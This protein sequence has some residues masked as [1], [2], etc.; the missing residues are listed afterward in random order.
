MY[1]DSSTSNSIT[2]KYIVVDYDNALVKEED[3]YLI[4]YT[5]GEDSTEEYTTEISNTASMETFTLS[6]LTNET[7]YNI[8]YN[9]ANMAE[10]YGKR[11][12]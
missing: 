6:N 9:K 8:Y 7:I 10:K 4:H 1:I 3:K 11:S 5:V 2:Y 12:C